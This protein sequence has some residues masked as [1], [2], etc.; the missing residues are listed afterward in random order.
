MDEFIEVNE[1]VN[2]LKDGIILKDI[3]KS[4]FV[5]K[6]EKIHVYSTNSSYS[7]KI[8]EFI[9]LFKDDKF[10]IEDFDD[11]TIDVEKDKEYY[12]FKHK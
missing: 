12:S 4:L 3:N 7:L 9:E 10:I 1:A 8:D 5:Y 2:L 11:N 6:K